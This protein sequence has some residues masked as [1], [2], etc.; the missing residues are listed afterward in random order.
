MG[1]HPIFE[2]D[3]DCLTECDS[4]CRETGRRHSHRT[5][6][7]GCRFTRLASR[8]FM[9]SSTKMGIRLSSLRQLFRKMKY[10]LGKTTFRRRFERG[11]VN[12]EQTHF[13]TTF[14]MYLPT[15]ACLLKIRPLAWQFWTVKRWKSFVPC[16]SLSRHVCVGSSHR[17][18][19]SL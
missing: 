7:H 18:K 6:K 14:S 3:F 1:T 8:R 5:K 9:V 15:R 12:I 2:S 19:C 4:F 13:P 11:T 10:E 17:A 16:L